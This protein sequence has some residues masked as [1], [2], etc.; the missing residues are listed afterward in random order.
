MAKILKKILPILA[1]V[2]AVLLIAT[3]VLGDT[4]TRVAAS[5]KD[6]S[7]WTANYSN[8]ATE[9]RFGQ[10]AGVMTS[11]GMI[12][13]NVTMPAGY[14]VSSAYITFTAE[15]TRASQG[16][17]STTIWGE[18]A[19]APA[20]YGAAEDISLRTYTTATVGWTPAASWTLNSTY[21]TSDITAIIQELYTSYAPYAAG[22]IAIRIDCTS[23]TNDKYQSAWSYDG[24]SAKAPLLVIDIAPD[25]A[26]WVAGE[27]S[28]FQ[29]TP[30]HWA[31]S[32]GGAASADNIPDHETNVF[33]DA[34]SGILPSPLDDIGWGQYDEPECHDMD[35]TGV[36]GTPDVATAGGIDIYGSV[37][38]SAGM[39]WQ[40]HTHLQGTGAET[41]TSNGVE[42]DN[43]QV[44]GNYTLA[45]DLDLGTGAI[46]IDAGASFDTG[47]FDIT[48]SNLLSSGTLT[49]GSS[50]I[51]VTRS[52]DI[53]AGTVNAGTST[54]VAGGG[55]TFQ[56]VF[57]GNGATYNN[58]TIITST[59]D[60]T[61][62]YSYAEIN[63]ANTFANLTLTGSANPFAW[64][65][66]DSNQVITGTL[67]MNGNAP[68]YRLLVKSNTLH[69]ARTL[70]AATVVSSYT[71]FRDII[72]AGAG[73]WN[74]SA[75]TAGDCGGNTG[76]TF[77]VPRTVYAVNG[78]GNYDWSD[79]SQLHWSNLSGSTPNITYFPRPQDT[80]VFDD[81]SIN[82]PGVS[83]G[84]D[85]LSIS[86]IEAKSVTHQPTFQHFSV[87][88]TEV[89]IY[90]SLELGDAT[91]DVDST[92]MYGDLAN[93][94]H[95]D[96]TIGGD[97]YID[98]QI[99]SVT[100]TSDVALKTLTGD[101]VLTSG[102]LDTD[103]YDIDTA[104]FNT[105]TNTY[106]R[107]L[108]MSDSVVTLDSASTITKWNVGGDKFSL[109]SGTSK[110]VFTSTG[111]GTTS[112]FAGAGLTYYDFTIEGSG[113]YTT[114][115]SGV[116]TF[117]DMLID[118]TQAH[119]TLS[120]SVDCTVTHLYIPRH[121]N[122]GV[123]ITNTD[124][125]KTSG[126]VYTGYL[127]I[128]GSDAFGGATFYAGTAP[129][130]VDGGS[131]TGWIFGEATA[132]E[133]SAMAATG[134]G[135]T[136]ATIRGSIDD[137]NSW[138]EGYVSFEYGITPAYGSNTTEVYVTALGTQTAY[139]ASLLPNTIY[140]FR[141]DLRYNYSDYVYTAELTFL[142]A[143][144]P[145]VTTHPATGI[146]IDT[147]ILNG[148]VDSLGVYTPVFAYFEYGL[149]LAYERGVTAEQTFITPSAFS[150]SVTYLEF[151][152]T[153]H[154][155][156]A[157][158][159]VIGAT[160]YYAT[161]ADVTFTLLP[162]GSSTNIQIKSAKMFQ[163]YISPNN[164]DLLL[165]VEGVNNY[166]NL[167][168]QEPPSEHFTIQLVATDNTTILGASPLANWGDRPSAIYWN[169]TTVSS[170]ITIGAAYYVRMV[171]DSK[172][173][174]VTT[175]YQ[176]IPSSSDNSDWRG[177]DL[178]GLDNWCIGT[179]TRMGLTDA[180]SGYYYTTETTN[181]G[182][183][184]N[185]LGGGYFTMG[186]PAIGQIRPNIFDTAEY[187]IPLN[188]GTASNI[189]DSATAWR[190]F[191]GNNIAN[192]ADTMAI[193]F[194]VTGKD[195]LAVMVMFAMLGCVMVVL[196]S[197]MTQALGA[198]FIAIPILWLGTY[199][200]IVPIA[201]IVV[202][203]IIAGLAAIRQFVIKT[204]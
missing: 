119:K 197:G 8:N 61:T 99:G 53:S 82:V 112:T 120:G 39:T 195:F 111:A 155:R 152:A 66:I 166:T 180:L 44:I 38:M 85:S 148:S 161:G 26:Y 144:I 60:D 123:T 67:T 46:D 89:Y 92:Y 98:T 131:N 33:F 54:I 181:R 19:S 1:G 198:A 80:A 23:A 36:T 55:D 62:E 20:D 170:N 13:D 49:L 158:R 51:T 3:P 25:D 81:K 75:G 34:N 136:F 83:I 157:V 22:T 150:Q 139:V 178:T 43:L 28:W 32:S 21:N 73:S 194:G 97:L 128:S 102:I 134:L 116:N 183:V 167:Y 164:G 93:L 168:P 125:I 4:S 108:V 31:I 17:I 79:A 187:K 15:F 122:T 11:T 72:G 5:D 188:A 101:L 127:T 189:W 124:F 37:I 91:W 96:N 16:T 58:V 115:I 140:Y 106:Q 86:A 176:L 105:I 162:P 18:N 153:Y 7:K 110:I 95:C 171:G 56:S 177:F 159:Y 130:S 14:H 203:V 84:M 10:V 104:T 201:I 74:L 118:R 137:W 186:I 6:T 77:P 76:L 160:S 145:I 90:G 2:L 163:N 143:G 42:M 204:M 9:A 88:Q 48:G 69:T 185:Y 165:V 132:P 63:D 193:P 52:W 78:S 64:V 179:A 135:N 45:D 147:A 29:S 70:T 40:A 12:F 142:T 173:G 100:M 174:Y 35:W 68:N 141:M 146:N 47:N 57:D 27:G 151:G 121:G 71:D 138:T 190:D 129:P 196:S 169:P 109:S 184:I 41:L 113:D 200:R 182:T 156:A 175:Q 202:I 114:T 126:V 149:T 103:G 87:T 94:L 154:F 192:D 133:V 50:N 117:H 65:Q 30:S 24:D 59:D 191:V 199:F 172:S 107:S